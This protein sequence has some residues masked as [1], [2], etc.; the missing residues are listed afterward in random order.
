MPT[1]KSPWEQ[2]REPFPP[3]RVLQLP[4]TSKRPELDYVSHADVTDR[5]L[6]V[7]PT[8]SWEWGVNDPQTG[9]PS[10]ALSLTLE[11]DEWALW[12]AL[13]VNGSTKRD[14]GYAAA[15]VYGSDGKSYPHPEALKHVVS[16]AL[17]RCAMRFGVALDLWQ[18]ADSGTGTGAGAP[19][20]GGPAMS[21][22][23]CG[24]P[25]RDRKGAK[26]PFVGCSGYPECKF[27][28]NGTLAELA[29]D[30]DGD[31]DP[32]EINVPI[33]PAPE[34]Q[35]AEPLPAD[36]LTAQVIELARLAGPEATLKAFKAVDAVDCLSMS[37]D[38]RYRM[39]KSELDKLS[40]ETKLEIERLL[41]IPF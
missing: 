33:P 22:P 14:V 30:L 27:T 21:C 37:A 35:A 19:P 36:K 5:L 18:K 11:H 39:R 40:E 31:V 41:E 15:L 12:M 16:D 25:L 29:E 10:K 20:Q 17:R 32:D 1:S 34:P 4:A 13:T 9:L 7:D 2:L 8:W 28:R 23:Q 3:E 38:G 26:G 24:K 6:A